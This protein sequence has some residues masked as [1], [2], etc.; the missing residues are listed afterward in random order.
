VAF[1]AAV[2]SKPRTRDVRT[3]ETDLAAVSSTPNTAAPSRGIPKSALFVGCAAMTAVALLVVFFLAGGDQPTR[4]EGA[5]TAPAFAPEPLVSPGA[6][7]AP[8]PSSSFIVISA[9]DD[10][11]TSKAKTDPNASVVPKATAKEEKPPISS[12]ADAAA[13]PP[14]ENAVEPA[15]AP[16]PPSPKDTALP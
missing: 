7:P 14:A 11:P 16:A 13:A 9:P 6:Q 2:T 15:P 10:P 1:L 3:S 12:T 4:V 8:A 5:P